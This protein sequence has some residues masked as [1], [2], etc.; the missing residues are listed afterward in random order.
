MYKVAILTLFIVSSL[1]ALSFR[2]AV[3][4]NVRFAFDEISKIYEQKS[5]I[6]AVAIVAS[7]GKLTAQIEHG[8][9]YNLF[10]SA[11]MK[12]PNYLFEKNLAVSKPK[13]YALGTLVLWSLNKKIDVSL[14]GMKDKKIKKIAIPNPKTAPYGVQALAVLKKYN[15]KKQLYSKIVF[16]ESVS[17]TNQYIYSSA[18]D[19]GITAKS[20]VMSPSMK[21]IGRFK[22]INSEDY[23]PIKQGIVILKYGDTKNHKISLD[24]YHFMFSSEVQKILTKYGYILP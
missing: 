3:A 20:V 7:S 23:S 21:N 5:G 15:L 24:F 6:R 10:L 8:A 9:P 19:I 18:A 22:E 17:Q 4:A 1:N 12:Y 2:V 11:N 13:I 14:E 16:G